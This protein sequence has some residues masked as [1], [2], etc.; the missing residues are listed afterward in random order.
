MN[1]NLPPPPPRLSA[2]ARDLSENEIGTLIL[3][4]A[5]E[6]HR[7]L[8]PGL[9][10]TVYEAVLAHELT[11]RGL[12]VQR[13]VPIPIS[14]QDQS[15]DEG[16]RADLIVNQKVILELKSVE[17][18]SAAHRK[19]IQT[20]LKLSGLKLGYLLNFG[21]ALLKEGIVRAVNN[22]TEDEPRTE[23]LSL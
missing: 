2:S 1:P 5:I 23:S 16:F 7:Q 8:G 12:D 4:S 10:E 13:Q 6:M 3:E 18:L 9:L 22:L 21:A 11:R 17:K 14:Y 15:F 19:Q 20:Y